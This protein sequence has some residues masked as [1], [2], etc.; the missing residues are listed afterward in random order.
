MSALPARAPPIEGE[1][2]LSVVRRATLTMGYETTS[3]IINL[4][5]NAGA[6]PFWLNELQTA[7]ACQRLADLLGLTVSGLTQLTIHRYAQSLV[8]TDAAPLA[9]DNRTRLR[10]FN[11]QTR[12]C[13]QCLAESSTP[14]EKLIWSFRPAPVCIHHGLLLISRCPGC[15]RQIPNARPQ[16]AECRCG[17]RLDRLCS[18][19]LNSEIVRSMGVT[20]AALESGQQMIPDT[21]LPAAFFWLERMADAVGKCTGW[22]QRSRAAWNLND[23][24]TDEAVSWLA[25]AHI[26]AK[27]PD[28]LFEFLDVYVREPKYRHT[29]TGLGRTLGRLHRHASDLEALGHD[30]PACAMRTYLSGRYSAGHINRK[31]CLFREVTPQLMATQDWMPKTLAAAEL[32]VS[33]ATVSRL[34]ADGV[35][36][37]ELHQAGLNG[38]SVGVVS[39][40]SLIRLKQQLDS[41]M[42]LTEAAARLGIDRHRVTELLRAGVLTGAVHVK[43][44]WHIPIQ[45]ID[46][47]PRLISDLQ[48]MQK[49]RLPFLTLR[50]ATRR[51]GKSGFTFASAL[52]LII[53]GV[54]PAK[55]TV[56]GDSLASI[57][58]NVNDIERC[59]SKIEQMRDDREG[60]PLNRL[61]KSL[62]PNRP[63]KERVLKKWI[64]SGLLN[65][66]RAGQ[67]WSVSRAEVERFRSTYCLAAEACRIVARHRRTLATWETAGHLAP[68]YGPRVTP[69]AGFTLYR[70]ADVQ[71]L[72]ETLPVRRRRATR[73]NRAPTSNS[74]R[75]E[76]ACT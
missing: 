68:V 24:C 18:E 40:D 27:W 48:P 38:K 58:V 59:R 54:L 36:N 45:S 70:R 7:T 29:A 43:R 44:S 66:E 17:H 26:V 61:A 10:Y 22:K 20:T 53:N 64:Q 21:S 72:M 25:A 23:G 32:Q 6:I 2:L 1:S 41:S 11:P 9:C 5:R 34:L 76:E 50:E 4:S 49:T 55:R 39:R 12:V 65:A 28:G 62:F 69:G 35:L 37:G 57:M 52:T 67:T 15:G 3:Q 75:K 74:P 56:N 14:F 31:V 16:N 46:D 13:P 47:V 19:Q 73:S 33:V 60:V 71:R 51:F 8:L 63:T 42:S 30:S